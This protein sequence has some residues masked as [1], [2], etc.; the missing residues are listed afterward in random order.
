MKHCSLLVIVAILFCFDC[1]ASSSKN[2]KDEKQTHN[3][4]LVMTGYGYA[5]TSDINASGSGGASS[6]I[7][8][9]H[10]LWGYGLDLGTNQTEG[11]SRSWDTPDSYENCYNKYSDWFVGPSIYLFPVNSKYHR[12]HLGVGGNFFDYHNTYIDKHG[13]GQNYI[14]NK[15]ISISTGQ[16][17]MCNIG[18]HAS[19]GY[20]VKFLKHL[21]LG[22]R[23]YT[24]FYQEGFNLNALVNLSVSF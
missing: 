21:E 10:K 19:A 3:H 5:Y 2:R 12:I 9:P 24:S 22:V 14:E 8:L 7:Y 4:W 13:S 17:A 1:F 23:A 16:S 20:S 11:V 18:F 6:I 15:A